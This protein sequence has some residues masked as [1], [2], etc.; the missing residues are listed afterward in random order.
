MNN[1]SNALIFLISESDIFSDY[2]LGMYCSECILN[3][4]VTVNYLHYNL[5]I[6]VFFSDVYRDLELVCF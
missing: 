2:T 5:D 1:I 3:C 4:V 6:S